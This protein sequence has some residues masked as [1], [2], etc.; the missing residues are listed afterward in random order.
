M[1]IAK[2][3]YNFIICKIEI[4]ICVRGACGPPQFIWRNYIVLL[5]HINANWISIASDEVHMDKMDNWTIPATRQRDAS[6]IDVQSD[7]EQ[8]ITVSHR[9]DEKQEN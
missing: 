4:E 9:C 1:K 6:Q 2:P 7:F 3:F 5:L 8:R